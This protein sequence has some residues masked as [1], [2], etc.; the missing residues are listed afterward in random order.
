MLPQWIAGDS[1]RLEQIGFLLT[2]LG[3]IVS[4]GIFGILQEDVTRG[5]YGVEPDEKGHCEK[6]FVYAS[7]MVAILCIGNFVFGKSTTENIFF[8]FSEL[9]STCIFNCLTAISSIRSEPEDKTHYGYYICVSITYA[10]AMVA[11][12]MALQWISYPA[13]VIG[14]SAKPIPVMILGVIIGRKSYSIQR[15]FFVF[16]IVIGVALF[17]LKTDK[18]GQSKNLI[19][20]GEAL[21]ILSLTMD[22]LTGNKN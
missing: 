1:E 11:S 15:Y 22:G 10:T 16:T 14:K 9:I 7:T 13:A 19:G 20:W 18:L 3:I 8:L 6:K 5:C 2:A 12:N 4:Y 17:L 21:L